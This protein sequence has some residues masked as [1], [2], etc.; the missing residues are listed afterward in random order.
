MDEIK[1]YHIKL[2]D[3]EL[4]RQLATTVQPSKARST[5]EVVNCLMDGF[6]HTRAVV[7]VTFVSV[8]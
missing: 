5:D 3:N 7:I 1:A 4:K 6:V 2:G 8:K